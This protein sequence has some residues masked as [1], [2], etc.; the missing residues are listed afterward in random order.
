VSTAESQPEIDPELDPEEG[1]S[2]I[3]VV[4]DDQDIAGFV[5]FNLKL[6]GFEV[7]RAKDGQGALDPWRRTGPISRSWT[8]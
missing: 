6:R 2:L 4:D 5:E 1:P 8:G 3:L 7:I